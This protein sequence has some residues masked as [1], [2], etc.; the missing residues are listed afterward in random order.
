MTVQ[1]SSPIEVLKMAEFNV[2]IVTIPQ[3]H[4]SLQTISATDFIPIVQ[5]SEYDR[6]AA[7]TLSEILAS[8]AVKNTATW[9]TFTP[10]N[11]TIAT[12]T[13]DKNALVLMQAWADEI[14][15]SGSAIKNS[16]MIVIPKWGSTGTKVT[17]SCTFTHSVPNHIDITITVPSGNLLIVSFGNN[18]AVSEYA[19][20]PMSADNTSAIFKSLSVTN[21]VTAGLVNADNVNVTNVT[22]TNAVNANAVNA[23][24]VVATGTV[25][26]GANVNATGN[27]HAG[28]ITATNAVNANAVNATN[29][30]ATNAVNAENVTATNAVNA[31][32]VNATG[33]VHVGSVVEAANVT[34]TGNVNAG[35]I[36]HSNNNITADNNITATNAVNANAVNATD[37]TATRNVNAE[38]VTATSGVSAA[39]VDAGTANVTNANATNV[40]ITSNFTTTSIMSYTANVDLSTYVVDHHMIVGQHLFIINTGT[41]DITVTGKVTSGSSEITK[42]WTLAIG[43]MCDFVAVPTASGSNAIAKLG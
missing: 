25:N 26:A 10:E 20:L 39:V 2:P 32:A 14:G 31:N 42:T 28:D 16:V 43:T 19:C 4:D 40:T 5:G 17:T 6:D 23:T 9:K 21:A 33:H 8:N 34:A 30:T 7:A 22:A 15:N 35:D 3:L 13:W 41:A 29:V 38:N 27:V 12:G 24:N 11:G 36:I 18:G 1:I 37:V